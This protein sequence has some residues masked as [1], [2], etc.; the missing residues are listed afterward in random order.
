VQLLDCERYL[1]L[2]VA[3]GDHAAEM[4]FAVFLVSGVLGRFD[5]EEARTLL[6]RPSQ[7]SRFAALLRDSLSTLDC[8]L[9][10]S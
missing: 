9:M 5:F 3:Q 6:E 1:R 2:A 10:S 8:E 7:S 4:R